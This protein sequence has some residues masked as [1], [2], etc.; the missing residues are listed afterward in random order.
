MYKIVVIKGWLCI[1]ILSLSEKR[2]TTT[3]IPHCLS[4][5]TYWLDMIITISDNF[6][7][8]SH[9]TELFVAKI[10]FLSIPNIRYFFMVFLFIRYFLM[11]FYF[12]YKFKSLSKRFFFEIYNLVYFSCFQIQYASSNSYVWFFQVDLSIVFP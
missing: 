12:L 1:K 8:F 6:G 3:F 2:T 11:V 9:W 7:F 10:K 4:P 5:S